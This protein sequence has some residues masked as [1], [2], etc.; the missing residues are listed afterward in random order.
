M[1]WRHDDEE[2]LRELLPR[3]PGENRQETTQRALDLAQ[4]GLVDEAEGLLETLPED[5]ES[6]WDEARRAATRGLV[7]LTR[8]DPRQSIAPL[9]DSLKV[10]RSMSYQPH[11]LVMSIRLAEA[12]EALGHPDRALRVLEEASR[13][14]ARLLEG[15]RFYWMQAELRRSDLYRR[16]GRRAEAEEI[17]KELW[18]LS[19]HSDSDF[20][21]FQE[22]ERRRRRAGPL[23]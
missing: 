19:I 21:I 11:Y 18:R 2:R 1:A 15:G 8:G 6:S 14:K 16:L 17:E 4:V 22:L 23:G 12:W 7:A 5:L 9:Q 20:P 13:Q 3:E 10:L